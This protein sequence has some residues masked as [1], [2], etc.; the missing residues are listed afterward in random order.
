MRDTIYTLI[1]VALALTALVA[2]AAFCWLL[3]HADAAAGIPLVAGCA[4]WVARDIWV[5]V[6]GGSRRIR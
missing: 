1:A 3:W 4:A 5:D 2:V 6:L